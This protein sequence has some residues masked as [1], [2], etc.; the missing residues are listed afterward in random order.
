MADSPKFNCFCDKSY[1]GQTSRHSKTRIKEYLPTC[2]IKLI[3]KEPKIITIATENAT[4]RSSV[5]EHLVNNKECAKN[6]DSSRFKV[7]HQCQNAMDLIKMEAIS[8][9][10]EKPVLYKQKEFDFKVS[11]VS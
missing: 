9:Y 1:I 2:V 8:I 3:E 10:L 7:L 11:L 6:Y 4:K 5:A